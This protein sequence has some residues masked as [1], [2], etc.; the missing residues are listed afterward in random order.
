MEKKTKTHDSLFLVL[1]AGFFA[2]FFLLSL[3]LPEKTFSETENRNLR[4]RPAF[5]WKGYFSGK[6][7]EKYEQYLADQFPLRD[8]WITGKAAA[9]RGLAK[10]ENNGILLG[11]DGYL[12]KKESAFDDA[13]LN[14]NLGFIQEFASRYQNIPVT[15]AVIPD[16]Y[17]VYPEKLPC[18][19]VPLNQKSVLAGIPQK[20]EGVGTGEVFSVL[21][22]HKEEQIF[23]RTDHHWTAM[24]AYYAY[25][26]LGKNLGYTP[27]PLAEYEKKEI[28]NFYGTYYNKSKSFLQKGE[29]LTYYDIPIRSMHFSGKIVDSLY[30][31]EKF[32]TS[33]K[34]SAFL[35]GNNDVTTIDTQPQ[36]GQK[37]R[38]LV[39][40]DS[41][42]NSLIP[43]LTAHYE[44]IVV[45]DLRGNTT[46]VSELMKT[47]DFDDVLLLYSFDI[48]KS[49][50]NLARIT[51]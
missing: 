28:P 14:K 44:E 41:F 47:M 36:P 11:K 51:Y 2:L 24:G 27:V 1:I 18:G 16:K 7:E 13:Q 49:D 12:F 48:L 15:L 25:E 46:P 22:V 23:Y 31:T 33:D 6:Y 5:T 17:A 35:W 45:V 38:L 40:K 39:F 26:S 8:I 43:F 29:V 30:Q 10:R 34:Y 19:F 9:E 42:A 37:Q 21:K 32:E 3:L 20:L 50:T 4:V